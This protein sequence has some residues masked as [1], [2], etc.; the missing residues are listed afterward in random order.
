[1]SLFRQHYGAICANGVVVAREIRD[2][3]LMMRIN[4]T[5][6]YSLTMIKTLLFE[7][8]T[9]KDSIVSMVFADGFIKAKSKKLKVMFGC[10]GFICAS[11]EMWCKVKKVACMVNEECAMKTSF[12]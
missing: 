6:G 3:V 7:A 12:A 11:R 1:M 8:F 5:V 2:S 9:S 4:T 10:D